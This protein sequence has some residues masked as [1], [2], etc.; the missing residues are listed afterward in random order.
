MISYLKDINIKKSDTWKIQLTIAINF[1][2]SNDNDEE[3]AMHSE[4][5]NIKIMIG[6][7]GD[8]VAEELF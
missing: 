2:Y 5:N 1:I 8:Q 3:S 7:K 4:S 6:D